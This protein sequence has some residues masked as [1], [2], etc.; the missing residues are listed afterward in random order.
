MASFTNAKLTKLRNTD[1]RLK[2]DA[3]KNMKHTRKSLK[4]REYDHGKAIRSSFEHSKTLFNVDKDLITN[5]D[6]EYNN[7][8]DDKKN[9]I[10]E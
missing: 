6:V 3:W 2:L 4:K 7:F 8:S 1:F 9:H 10:K 5:C